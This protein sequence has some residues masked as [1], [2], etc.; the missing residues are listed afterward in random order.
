M[1]GFEPGSKAPEALVISR[2]NYMPKILKEYKMNLTLVMI[3]ISL[4]N[5]PLARIP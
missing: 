2:L 1:P 5:L 3:K 4:S